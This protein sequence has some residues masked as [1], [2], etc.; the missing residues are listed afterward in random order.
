M[1]NKIKSLENIFTGV[2]SLRRISIDLDNGQSAVQIIHNDSLLWE[3]EQTQEIRVS[4]DCV[5]YTGR[6]IQRTASVRKAPTVYPPTAYY[7][8][9]QAG[10]LRIDCSDYEPDG[11]MSACCEDVFCVRPI[12]GEPDAYELV[13]DS[14]DL[15]PMRYIIKI[16]KLIDK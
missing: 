12:P 6:Y 16:V 9:P 8:D 15:S 11:F 2:W 5:S 7:Y 3:F 13:H 1:R 10:E 14:T 4:E